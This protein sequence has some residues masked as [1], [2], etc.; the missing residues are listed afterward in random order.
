MEEATPSRAAL[1]A[2]GGTSPG[3]EPA[4]AA[5]PPPFGKGYL[6]AHFSLA[7]KTRTKVKLARRKLMP[8]LRVHSEAHALEWCVN[9]GSCPRV[10]QLLAHAL[11][12][13]FAVLAHALTTKLP[14]PVKSL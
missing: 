11:S 5:A 4:T 14:A 8:T 9:A 7:H 12:Y 13:C 6:A 1:D 2:A 3:G 10:L